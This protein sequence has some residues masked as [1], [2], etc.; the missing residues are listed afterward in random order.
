MRWLFFLNLVS[1]A[2]GYLREIAIIKNYGIGIETDLYIIINRVA[3]GINTE[4][5]LVY[6]IIFTLKLVNKESIN[7]NSLLNI[8]IIIAIVQLLTILS[9]VALSYQINI[10][11]FLAIASLS[12]LPF[13]TSGIAFFKSWLEVKKEKYIYGTLI[14][15][16]I[17]FF[18]LSVLIFNP[19]KESLLQLLI[20]AIISSYIITLLIGYKLTNISPLKEKL[21]IS[22]KNIWQDTTVKNLLLFSLLS[23]LTIIIDLYA[24]GLLETG[25]TSVFYFSSLFLSIIT[26]F[27]VT[28]I[29]TYYFPKVAKL[30]KDISYS[31]L[32]KLS[33]LSSVIYI[34]IL[35]VIY[36]NLD[37]IS[38]LILENTEDQQKITI[39]TSLLLLLI[40]PSIIKEN[41]KIYFRTTKQEKI[42]LN[43]QFFIVIT[44]LIISI[45]MALVYGW[46]GFMF[47]YILINLISNF[48]YIILFINLNPKSINV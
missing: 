19:Q 8:T 32:M 16:G 31:F 1:L 30:S 29:I 23:Q 27:Y 40:I 24:L 47:S 45:P 15:I 4:L 39:T 26:Y 6:G 5:Y 11:L 33:I 35:T 42:N 25:N 43:I 3:L 20:M 34:P 21:V 37:F 44:K 13:L 22:I 7:N 9:L 2:L 46:F 36:F 14:R 12:L 48:A 41:I 38:S 28:V 18:I 10:E 17:S